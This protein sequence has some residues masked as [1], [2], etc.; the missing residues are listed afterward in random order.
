MI[1]S[2]CI[3]SRCLGHENL[4]MKDAPKLQERLA[5]AN[6]GASGELMPSPIP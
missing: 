2:Y 1:S 3:V 4:I 5:D 6:E